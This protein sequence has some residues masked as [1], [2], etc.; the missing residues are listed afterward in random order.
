MTCFLSKHS[1]GDVSLGEHSQL[2]WYAIRMRLHVYYCTLPWV[3]SVW[4]PSPTIPLFLLLFPNSFPGQLWGQGREDQLTGAPTV[5][6][7]KV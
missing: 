4:S 5:S 2:P 1:L 3:F 6:L 7:V